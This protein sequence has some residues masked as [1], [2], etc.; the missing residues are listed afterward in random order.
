MLVLQQIAVLPAGS[1]IDIYDGEMLEISAVKSLEDGSLIFGTPYTAEKYQKVYSTFRVSEL[2]A[3]IHY[4]D[5]KSS[6]IFIKYKI[7]VRG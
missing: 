3:E 5:R 7:Q 2:E 4:N 1:R 6:D